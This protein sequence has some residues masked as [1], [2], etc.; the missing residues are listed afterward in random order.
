PNPIT[1]HIFVYP[2]N[3]NHYFRLYDVYGRIHFSGQSIEEKNLST[4]P[5]GIYYLN[6]NGSIH[7]IFKLNKI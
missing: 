3:E 6:I 7:H 1:N 4:L 5:S 2:Q